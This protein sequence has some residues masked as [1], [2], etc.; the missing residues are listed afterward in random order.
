[1]ATWF[2]QFTPEQINAQYRKCLPGLRADLRKAEK[3]G[4]KVRGNSAEVLHKWIADIEN[5][6]N[7][8]SK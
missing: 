7:E 2:D 6:L 3:T 4:K 8:P 1:M 5:K